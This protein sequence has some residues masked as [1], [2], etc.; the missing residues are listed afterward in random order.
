MAD[1][2]V[3]DL[4][5]ITGANTATG[6]LFLVDDVSDTTDDASGT[7]KKITRAELASAILLEKP[8][9]AAIEALTSAADKLPYFTGAGT[10]ALADL[11]TAG[12]ALIDDASAAAQATTLG[13]GTGDSPQ[14]TAVNIGAAADTTVTRTG[15][16][17]IA[18]EGNAL[19]RAGGTDVPVA[20]GGTG[21]STAAGAATNLGLGTGDSP[22]FT[23]VNVGH[24]SDTTLARS[25]AGDLTVEGNAIYRAGGTDV[26]IT[27]G[28]TG[29]ST[30]A[31][32]RVALG[33]VGLVPLPIPGGYAPDGSG[34]GNNPATPEKI[35]SSGTQTTNSP[36]A[37]YYGLLFDPTT[38]EHWMWQF[39]IPA[40]YVSGGTL[41]GN[42]S[43]KGTSANGVTWKG[44]AAIGVAG[45]TDIDAIVFDTVVTANATPS[46]TTGIQTQFTIALTMT[47][48]AASRYIIVMIGR[49]PDNASD[50][51]ASDMR[52]EALN[53]EYVN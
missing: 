52:L 47:N 28:G 45:T 11:T 46:T 16:G 5:A 53:F 9:I 39:L 21:S 31:A 13:L 23:A 35:I 3:T 6:D 36:K 2:L 38:D 20:D 27:D 42:F 34:S 22:Q 10:A 19:Y 44:A 4:T 8:D 51:N 29:S 24:A 30:A 49:D 25:G 33:I 32:A 1:R 41:R 43:N 48:A 7:V 40:D 37:S 15:A 14:F 26:P 50:T 18:V 17:D 12:R